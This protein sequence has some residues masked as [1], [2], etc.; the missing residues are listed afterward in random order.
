MRIGQTAAKTTTKRCAAIPNGVKNTIASGMRATAGIG[1]RNSITTDEAS[2]N[3]R[4]L[5]IR[6]PAVTPIKSANASPSRYAWSVKPISP[7]SV[8]SASSS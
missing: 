6:T 8:P 4:E 1:R 5:P 7:E 3:V 2:S